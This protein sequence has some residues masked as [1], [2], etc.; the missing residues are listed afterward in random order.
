MHLASAIVSRRTLPDEWYMR[1]FIFSLEAYDRP[2][3]GWDVLI[4][5]SR[6]VLAT[7]ALHISQFLAAGQTKYTMATAV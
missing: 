3:H 7:H 2:M 5:W 6:W 1:I 4:R